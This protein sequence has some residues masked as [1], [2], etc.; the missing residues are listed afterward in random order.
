MSLQHH[1]IEFLLANNALKFGTFTLKS[2]RISPYF[3]NL[4]MFYTGRNLFELGKFY[5]NTLENCGIEYDVLFGPAYKGIPLVSATSIAL[6][7]EYKKNVPYCFNR[8]EAKDHGEGGNL[9]GAPLTGKVIML[10]DVITAGTTILETI[11]LMKNNQAELSSILIA[12]DRQEKRTE[13]A[14]QSVVQ[15]TAEKHGICIQSIITL[16]DLLEYLEDKNDMKK[17]LENIVQ[18]REKYGA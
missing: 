8:K 10:D 18:Y 14:T 17:H 15:E 16:Q 7:T 6:H 1:F 9:V 2:G 13:K 4:G 3:F 5:A 11:S 12:F